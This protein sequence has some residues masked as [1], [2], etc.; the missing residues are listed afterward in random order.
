MRHLLDTNAAISLLNDPR[1]QLACRARQHQ[2]GD[3]GLSSGLVK[4]F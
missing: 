4:I 3:I 1:G 2:P